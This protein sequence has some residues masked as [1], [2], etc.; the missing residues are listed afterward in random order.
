[1]D[2]INWK[3]PKS[4]CDLKSLK[5]IHINSIKAYN[6]TLIVSPDKY[7]RRIDGGITD[8]SLESKC[9]NNARNYKAEPNV[10]SNK[11]IHLESEPKCLKQWPCVPVSKGW[12]QLGVKKRTAP[13]SELCSG[14]RTSTTQAPLRAEFNPTIH[15]N[16]RNEGL[17]SW[18]FDLY[19]QNGEGRVFI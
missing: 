14:L 5:N 18:M 9:Y 13:D 7:A 2:T 8:T 1:M 12:D 15:T 17:Y 3:A 19:N 4:D 6:S 11:W 16:P 10:I